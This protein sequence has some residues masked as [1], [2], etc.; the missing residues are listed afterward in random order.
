[1]WERFDRA[2]A[3]AYAPAARYFAQQAAL[4]KEAR[5]QREEFIAT[6]DGAGAD[7]VG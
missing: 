4:Q 6:A 7:I 5:R 2:C 3:K 1:M